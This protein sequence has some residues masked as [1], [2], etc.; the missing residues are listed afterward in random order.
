MRIFQDGTVKQTHLLDGTP[1]KKPILIPRHEYISD[2]QSPT[3][4]E[5]FFKRLQELPGYKFETGSCTLEPTH[6]TVQFGP[7]QAYLTCVPK[8]YR[9]QSSGDA[10]D[11]LAAEQARLEA[12]YDCTFNTIQVNQHY[13]HNAV[14]HRHPDSNPGHICM[15]SVGAV[16]DFVLSHRTYAD[17]ARYPLAHGSLLTFF[18]K[19]QWRMLHSMPRSETPC[20]IRFSVIFRYVPLVQTETMVMNIKN[21]SKSKDEEKAALN[22]YKAARDAE[23]EAA[24]RAGRIARGT[25]TPRVWDCH[26]GKFYPA[27][28]VYVGREVRDRRTGQLTWAATPF[29]NHLKLSQNAFREYATSKMLDADFRARVEALRGRDLLCWCGPNAEF[30]HAKV[31]LELA[32]RME[33]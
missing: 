26:A 17:F 1:M 33:P 15:I 16:R 27:D 9:V 6:S 25:H 12:K 8:I 32:N 3:E 23:Y 30:C 13:D 14:V 22:A 29:G 2:D 21:S 7:R 5:E 10:P 11:F 31:W 28:A 4:A 24:Q 18:P 19:D 20:G